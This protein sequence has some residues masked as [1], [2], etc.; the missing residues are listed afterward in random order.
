MTGANAD[1]GADRPV[2]RPSRR[3][4]PHPARSDR[5][6]IQPDRQSS[7]SS[8]T[9]PR[10]TLTRTTLAR[11]GQQDPSR[12][13]SPDSPRPNVSTKS[14]ASGPRGA[15]VIIAEGHDPVPHTGASGFVGLAKISSPM[16]IA[17]GLR[18]WGISRYTAVRMR[19]RSTRK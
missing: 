6:V 14:A 1:R 5:H 16:R 3:T 17:R 13:R 19:G 12:T 2:R 4:R 10:R 15:Q 8:Q 7:N 11:P 9:C 18:V